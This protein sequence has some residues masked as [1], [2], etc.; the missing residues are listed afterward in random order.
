MNKNIGIQIPEVP[1]FPKWQNNNINI[2]VKFQITKGILKRTERKDFFL[3]G[4][5]LIGLT[6]DFSIAT[7]EL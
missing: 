7:K 5:S 3:T 6:V 4:R 1:N 2:V